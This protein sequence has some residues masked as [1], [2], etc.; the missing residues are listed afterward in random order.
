MAAPSLHKF[1]FCY[2]MFSNTMQNT[3][4]PYHLP[5]KY[6][7]KANVKIYNIEYNFNFNIKF[8]I[9]FKVNG[10]EYQIKQT[11]VFGVFIQN[12]TYKQLR[13]NSDRRQ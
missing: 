11:F 3:Q 13:D 1:I 2:H 6:T 7:F 5:D 10:F 8:G 4:I 9:T 12:Y